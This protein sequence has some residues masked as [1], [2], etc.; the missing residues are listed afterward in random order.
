MAQ[1]A[2]KSNV[3]SNNRASGKAVF[4]AGLYVSQ[5]KDGSIISENHLVAN[6]TEN[7]GSGIGLYLKDTKSGVVVRKNSIIE[8]ACT[9]TDA[10]AGGGAFFDNCENLLFDSN[11]VQKNRSGY[12]CG[13]VYYYVSSGTIRNSIVSENQSSIAG[14][15]AGYNARVQ[16][17]NN[18]VMDNISTRYGGGISL[19]NDC[20]AI[21]KNNLILGNKAGAGGG[22]GVWTFSNALMMHGMPAVD[23]EMSGSATAAL[24]L[25]KTMADSFPAPKTLLLVNNTICNNKADQVNGYG[26]GLFAMNWKVRGI[27]NIIWGNQAPTFPN[28]KIMN[29][30][31]QLHYCS[32]EGGFAGQ[33]NLEEHPQFADDDRRLADASPCIG[34]GIA[35]FDFNGVLVTAPATDFNGGPRPQP[36]GS[37][38]DVGAFECAQQFPTNIL[39]Q[40][41]A[42][43]KYELLQ[44][45]PN[46]F[47][48]TTTIEYSL[49]QP[50][51]VSLAVYNLRGQMVTVLVDEEQDAGVHAIL[52]R[53]ED[54]AG[55]Q[56]GSGVYLYR[57]RATDAATGE[58]LFSEDRKMAL[59]R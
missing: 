17:L 34:A 55:A 43:N 25:Q 52:W 44:N 3:I 26:G 16:I 36:E 46:P 30:S 49:P 2:V 9:N 22:V 58:M 59:M 41:K 28:I 21:V 12:V 33:H 45:Y 32:I 47:N 20:Q 53:G 51:Q 19:M 4:S 7:R 18:R 38:P 6:S 24:S 8:N 14:G 54:G 40:I 1:A 29:A 57:L 13:G 37:N 5:A 56:V 39:S 42:P 23:G 35:E 27:N 50:A 10:G 31:V 48:P 11:I 15:I